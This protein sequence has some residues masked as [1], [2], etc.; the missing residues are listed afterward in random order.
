MA[1]ADFVTMMT[2]LGFSNACAVRF[3]ND[4]GLQD[5]EEFRAMDDYAVESLCK[6]TR[7]AGGLVPNPNAI[8]P[9]GANQDQITLAGRQAPS[10]R[11][12]GVPISLRAEE[13]LKLMCYQIRYAERTSNT[14]VFADIT[15]NSVRALRTQREAEKEHEDPEAPLLT[16]TDWPKTIE[17]IEEYLR[18]CLGVTKIPLSY[19]I[20]EDTTPTPTPA[21]GF[22][23]TEEE[24][25]QRAPIIDAAGTNNP[26][27]LRD[28]KKVWQI[29]PVEGGRKLQT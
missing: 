19:V 25:I 13:N 7:N 3:W 10:I 5:L 29:T 14:L 21:T 28:R 20:R 4:E 18:G 1:Q 6:V 23:T 11:D 22:A 26:T 17:T 24:L 2:G 27:Y 8:A 15:L 16:F 12:P 9:A